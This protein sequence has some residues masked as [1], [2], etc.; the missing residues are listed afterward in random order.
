LLTNIER[1]S[2]AVAQLTFKADHAQH[3]EIRSLWTTIASS[4]AFLLEREMRL[5]DEDAA[6]REER[7]F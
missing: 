4:Y 7:L 2:R 1:Y 3:A 6:R 5:E